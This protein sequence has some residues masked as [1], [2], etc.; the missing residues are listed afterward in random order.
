MNSL[1]R[2]LL[3]TE[4]TEVL[5]RRHWACL[6]R[7]ALIGLLF[8]ALALFI[9]TYLGDVGLFATSGALLLFGA[10]GWFGWV[11]ADWYVERFVITDK[12]VLL[13]NGLLTKRVAIMPL[14]K[15]TDLTYERTLIGRILG[16]G[17]FIVE[18]AGQDQALSRIDYLPTPDL[19]YHQVSALLFGPKPRANREDGSAGRRPRGIGGSAGGQ[20]QDQNTTPL[21]RLN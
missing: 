21:P 20:A 10:I 17:V 19:L 7:S 9:I 2:Y 8:V 3:P 1:E 13:I 12:R 6:A 11:V 5:V 16:Y 18:S 14:T 15:V 4:T